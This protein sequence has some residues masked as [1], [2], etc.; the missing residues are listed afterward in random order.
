VRNFR[1]VRRSLL[2]D[3]PDP[4][5]SCQQKRR[6]GRSTEDR[7]T[8]PEPGNAPTVV[9]PNLSDLS[10]LVPSLLFRFSPPV[11][12][13]SGANWILLIG[14][15]RWTVFQNP[16]QTST[17]MMFG[18]ANSVVTANYKASI[19]QRRSAFTDNSQKNCGD[20][21]VLHQ[22]YTSSIAGVSHVLV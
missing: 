17:P 21:D 14:V 22:V 10:E 20:A 19:F 2:I 5:I 11:Q 1:P 7:S 15:D 9:F 12:S 4:T 3:Y 16:T 13:Y 6:N 8:D 18:G